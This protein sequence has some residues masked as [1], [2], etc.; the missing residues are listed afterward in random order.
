[1]IE[2]WDFEK[3]GYNFDKLIVTT[4]SGKEFQHFINAEKTQILLD[5]LRKRKKFKTAVYFPTSDKQIKKFWEG[6]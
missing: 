3:R 6:V 4:K 5:R 2:K 1:M